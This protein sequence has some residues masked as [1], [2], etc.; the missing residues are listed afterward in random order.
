MD[1]IRKQYTPEEIKVLDAEQRIMRFIV[2]T[3]TVDRDGDILKAS[4]WNLDS[5]RKNPVVLFAHNYT[6][7]AVGKAVN[8]EV[9]SKRLVSDVQF[10]PTT[11]GNELWQLYSGGFMR[12]ASVGFKPLEW[13]EVE[14]ADAQDA[15]YPQGR[16]YKKQ[17]LLEWSLVPVPSNPDA[18]NYAR[19]AGIDTGLVEKAISEKADDAKPYENEYSCRLRDPGNFQDGTFKRGS[20]KHDGKEYGVIFGK[21]KGET[22]MTEQAYRYPHDTWGADD[23]KSHC[24]SHDGSWEKAVEEQATAQIDEL[25][26][27][28]GDEKWLSRYIDQRISENM[29]QLLEAVSEAL[30][31]KQAACEQDDQPVV[32]EAEFSPQIMTDELDYLKEL[33]AEHDVPDEARALARE[34]GEMLLRD[35]GDET[36]GSDIDEVE[37]VAPMDIGALIRQVWERKRNS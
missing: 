18:L 5:Y 36:A 4:G 6:Q 28:E 35:T 2:S 17:E 23:A 10:A 7:P 9:K 1:M 32:E 13:D 33:L 8:I 31:E 30:A 15:G 11:F 22:A 34:V 19:M 3:E 12:A 21:L 27:E 20:R 37:D 29:P 26:T 25:L 16:V 14:T 24:E